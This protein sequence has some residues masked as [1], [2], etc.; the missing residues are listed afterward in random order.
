MPNF[1]KR[2][3]CLAKSRKRGG[4]CIAGKEISNKGTTGGWIR[5]VSS[6]SSESI[7]FTECE[8]KDKTQPYL[9]D[10]VEIP[11]KKHKPNCFQCENYLIDDANKWSMSG[12]YDIKQLHKICDY[13][14]NLWDIGDSRSSYYGLRDRVQD[15]KTSEI[16]DSLYLITPEEL[17]IS[18]DTEGEE[19]G[20]PRRKVRV[21]FIYNESDYIFS[22]TDKYLEQKYFSKKNGEYE[23]EN[24]EDNIFM[25]ISIGLP[26]DDGF[27]YKFVAS[28][29]GL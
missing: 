16:K 18:V 12:T 8:C 23:I 20:N 26:Y 24:P 29:I 5:P 9:L 22:L 25:C 4:L 1:K 27:C 11:F 28:I 3:V 19:F 10:I 15:N 17:T 7:L 6:R 13:P 14:T 21:I 2:I